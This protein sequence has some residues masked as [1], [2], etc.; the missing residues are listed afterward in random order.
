M[1]NKVF[2][3]QEKQ[4][5]K[6]RYADVS[7]R[8]LARENKAPVE[9]V[10]IV[11]KEM[12]VALRSRGRPRS[13]LARIN[14]TGEVEILDESLLDNAEESNEEPTRDFFDLGND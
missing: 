8:Q 6:N 1:S 2:T 12:G 7:L 4:Q 3:E 5:M 10:R 14:R 13:P 11:L 9:Q